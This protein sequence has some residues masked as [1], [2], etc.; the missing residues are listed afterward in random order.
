MLNSAPLLL[1]IELQIPDDALAGPILAAFEQSGC[2]VSRLLPLREATAVSTSIRP[3]LI[4]VSL[5]VDSDLEVVRCSARPGHASCPIIALVAATSPALVAAA[6]AAGATEHVLLPCHPENLVKFCLATHRDRARNLVEAELQ[7]RLGEFAATQQSLRHTIDASSIGL[8][9]VD[10][11]GRPEIWNKAADR[12]LA[13]FSPTPL[14]TSRPL[15]DCIPPSLRQDY[16]RALASLYAGNDYTSEIN[17][18]GK[19]AESRWLT[20]SGTPIATKQGAL[21]RACLTIRESTEERAIQAELDWRN[22]AIS[23]IP[24]GIL[25][26]D[27]RYRIVFANGQ[28]EK[29]FGYTASEVLGRTCRFLQGPE[30]DQTTYQKICQCFAAG[31]PFAGRILNYRKD[32]TSLWNEMLITPV[33]DTATGRIRQFVGIQND[34]TARVLAEQ[35][36]IESQMRLKAIFD[37]SFTGILLLDEHGRIIESNIA[38]DLLFGYERAEFSRLKFTDLFAPE[39]TAG[40]HDFWQQL[41]TEGHS[42]GETVMRGRNGQFLDVEYDAMSDILKGLNLLFLR[43]IQEKKTLQN[44][45]L[46]QQRMESVGRLASG[47]AHDLNNILTPILMAP[48]LLRSHISDPSARSLLGNIEEGARRGA[49]IVRNLLEFSQ[50]DTGTRHETDLQKI[51]L[52]AIEMVGRTSFNASMIKAPTEAP[53][54]P[55]L[56]DSIQLQQAVIRLILNAIE[57]MPEGQHQEIKITCDYQEI[58]G[59]EVRRHPHARPGQFARLSVVD[60]GRGIADEDKQR[61]FDPFYSTRGFG[62]GRGLG[63]SVVMGIIQSHA[64]IIEIRSK[65]GVGTVATIALPLDMARVMPRKEVVPAPTPDLARAMPRSGDPAPADILIVDDDECTRGVIR[66]MLTLQGHRV[67]CA[68]TAESA[69]AHLKTLTEKRDLIILDLVMPGVTGFDLVEQIQRHSPQTPILIATG[70][71]PDSAKLRKLATLTAGLLYK[72]FT[73]T[74]LKN[75]ITAAL[76]HRPKID[77]RAG[78]LSTPTES[79]I[80]IGDASRPFLSPTPVP[81]NTVSL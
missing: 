12:L 66:I 63:L 77:V 56:A 38:A 7:V 3:D 35:E 60:H 58:T 36:L 26:T 57:S 31:K 43:D 49:D 24:H 19:E 33:R 71:I 15:L 41:H 30:T 81:V 46:R 4:V 80:E 62:N 22:H 69:L 37:H 61:I 11:E 54:L 52:Q 21:K 2:Q 25:I 17:L 55:V 73:P 6:Q 14:H 32:G 45:L 20:I 18:L 13:T 16:R 42:R 34:V 9:L 29:I 44:H 47:V 27:H 59:K 39:E 40:A 68:G 76:S 67:I 5:T 72:P 51:A 70:S 1:R 78:M 79:P 53:P 50:T 28:F 8:V 65:Q 74:D 10:P 75:A 23:S 48:A 64:G